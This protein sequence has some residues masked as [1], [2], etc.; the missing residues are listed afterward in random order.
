MHCDANIDIA[1]VRIGDKIKECVRKGI[2]LMKFYA[3]HESDKP[4]RVELEPHAADDVIIAGY[5]RGYYDEKNVFPIV[6][7]GIIASR[8]NKNFNANPY[9][10]IDA[11]LF[12]G[13]SG[14]LVISKPKAIKTKDGK[15]MFTSKEVFAFLG[16]Y[17]G[18]PYT[19]Q[20][21]IEFENFTIILKDNYNL[22]IVWYYHLVFEIIKN[23]VSIA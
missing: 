13:S 22:G 15:L 5:P 2:P 11:K 10:L 16:V 19:I 23:G 7:S 8:W 6:K 12:P 3:I 14:S 17:S 9:F 20:R 18:E 1:V 4:E 21:P